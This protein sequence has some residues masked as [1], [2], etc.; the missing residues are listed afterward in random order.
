MKKILFVCLGNICRSP[1]GEF[2]F[3]DLA[4]KAGRR[5]EFRIGSA[6]TSSWEIGNPVYPPAR[7]A[8]QR[9]GITCEG[10]QARQLTEEDYEAWDLI[11]AMDR[12]NMEDMQALFG[13]DPRHKL[14]LLM[15][16]AGESREVA[17]PYFTRDFE[18]SYED[19]LKGCQG[20]LK[21]I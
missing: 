16:F 17:D 10:K 13:G 21:S 1:M 4:E 14:R 18:K 9:H 7:E 3:K 20:L 6:A 11:L 2:V 19:I 12:R 5:D 15:E 8:L